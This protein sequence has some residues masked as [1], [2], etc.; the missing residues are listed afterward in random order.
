MMI[1]PFKMEKALV[2]VMLMRLIIPPQLENQQ[3]LF[4][5]Q[6]LHPNIAT[7]TVIMS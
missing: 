7:K 1:F 5:F 6:I 3:M 4:Q 2:K